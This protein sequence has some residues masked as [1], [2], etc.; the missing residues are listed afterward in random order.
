MKPPEILET[1]RLL[2]RLPTLEDA[3]PIFKKYAQDKEVSKYLIWRP[4]EN[5]DTTRLFLTAV[6]NAGAMVQLSPGS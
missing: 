2:L 1:T 6:P 5:I 3:A 4:H